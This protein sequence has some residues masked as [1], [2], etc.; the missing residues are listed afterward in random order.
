MVAIGY[1][2]CG[3]S[4]FGSRRGWDLTPPCDDY[5]PPTSWDGQVYTLPHGGAD[6]FLEFIQGP[7][8]KEVLS[9]FPGFM[10]DREI[11]VGHSFGGLCALHAL[12]TANT[13]FDTFVTI[14]PT[15]WWSKF[16]LLTEEARFL[17]QQQQTESETAEG[18]KPSLY[19][20][21]GYL[22]QYPRQR[23]SYS[24][25]EYLKRLAHAIALKT[26]DDIDEMAGRLRESERFEFVK[27]KEYVD[28]DH[29]SVAG[30]A[31]EWAVC[32]VLDPDR[33]D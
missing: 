22:E 21:Y 30:R 24:D 32:D 23:K 27:L 14:S 4:V 20:A 6:Q 8:R 1:P 29:G 26:K 9:L 28:D 11:L 16:F 25:D 12:F 7:I 31:L 5:D 17:E 15:T 13:C 19:L 3:A 10:P 18:K 2:D 33:F